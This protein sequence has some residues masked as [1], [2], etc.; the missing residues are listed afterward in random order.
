[1]NK[2]WDI[3]FGTAGTIGTITL[4]QVNAILACFAGLL[5]IFV[6]AMRA[7]REWRNRNDNTPDD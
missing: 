7:R 1:M 2:Q 4:A 6:M 5:T 3:I